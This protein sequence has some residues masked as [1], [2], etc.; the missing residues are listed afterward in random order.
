[1][2]IQSKLKKE[3]NGFLR[4]DML[5]KIF[6]LCDSS[7]KYST[8][9]KPLPK[10]SVLGEAHTYHLELQS[11]DRI[12]LTSVDLTTISV[13]VA[14]TRNYEQFGVGSLCSLFSLNYEQF[15]VESLCSPFLEVC[16]ER[17]ICFLSLKRFSFI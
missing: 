8:N 6:F 3:H 16:L 2:W 15:G 14:E 1:M 9:R 7:W 10:T 12:N 5:N 13:C 4:K 17:R 11:L